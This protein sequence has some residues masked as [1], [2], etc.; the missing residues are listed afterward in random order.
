MVFRVLSID[1]GGMRGL[2]TSTYLAALEEGFS[3]RFGAKCGLDIGS[4]FNLIVGTSTGAIIGCGIAQGVPAKE[5]A[6]LY[7]NNGRKIFPIVIPSRV[8]L[9]SLWSFIRRMLPLP[10][11]WNHL[12][13][14]ESG[15]RDALKGVFKDVTLRQ[16]YSER[17]IALAI[18]AVDM[19]TYRPWVFK[20]PHLSSSNGRDNDYQ[21]VD[22]C[23]ASS[24][25]PIYRSLAALKKPNSDEFDIFSDGG[26]WAN[27]PI[28]VAL[29]EAL[30]II[31]DRNDEESE[32]EIFCLGTF[33]KPEGRLIK[34]KKRCWGL[35]K[36][37]FGG[38]AASLSLSSQSVAFTQMARQ[39][40]PFLRAK[41]RI[42]NFPQGQSSSEMLEYLGLDETRITGMDAL[43]RQARRDA[44]TANSYSQDSSNVEGQSIRALFESMTPRQEMTVGD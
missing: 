20:T 27:N 19:A 3:N 34:P 16:L 14:G 8:D 44:D 4:A 35:R 5:M 37:K 9:R 39:I 6:D 7:R 25:A 30:R 17:K 2:Y 18:P 22:V 41:V 26:L 32:I 10:I 15:L 40:S 21:V 28:L 23:L 29:I 13:Q 42:I 43:M 12:S 36:W 1:G 33:A 11:R 38:E 31:E 24:A